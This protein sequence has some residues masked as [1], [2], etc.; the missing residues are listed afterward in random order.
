MSG[1][2]SDSPVDVEVRSCTDEAEAVAALAA[3][4]AVV[5]VGTDGEA[6]GRAARTLRE[7][8]PGRVAVLIGDPSDASVQSAVA[9][10]A[11]EVF[12]RTEPGTRAGRSGP[13]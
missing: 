5:L 6:L 7:A 10:L 12:E 4:A 1:A 13:E 3:G 2:L 9:D 11:A 8:W